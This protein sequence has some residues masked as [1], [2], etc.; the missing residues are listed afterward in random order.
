MKIPLSQPD[1]DES[2]IEAVVSVLRSN[3]LSL[4]PKLVEFEN[5]VAE[6][7]DTAHGVAVSSGTAGLHLALLALGIGEGDEVI[8]PSFAFIAVAN[9]VRQVRATPVFVDIDP[10]SLNITAESI[11]PAI[12]SRT[13][14]IL[15]VHT[16]GYP[17]AMGPII[18]LARKCNLR[19]IEDA[20]EAIGAEWNGRKAGSYGDLGVFSFYPNK[21]LT[22]GEGGVVVT[23][24]AELAH[25]IRALRNQGRKEGDGWL[26]HSMPGYNYRMP[27]MSCALGLS[28]L[29]RFETILARREAVAKKYY[30]A[31]EDCPDLAAPPIIVASGRISWFAFVVRLSPDLT[32]GER[33]RVVKEL[34]E[35]GIQARAYFPAIH[36]QP[37]YR[38]FAGG[39]NLAV[40]E[41]ISLRTL[42]L[43]F[44]NSLSW[45]QISTVCRELR[46]ILLPA[47]K[48]DCRRMD[49]LECSRSSN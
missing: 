3:Q 28:Q 2:D 34:G 48:K 25:T 14:A 42:A 22:T 33:D 46:G 4:G 1:I 17:A 9:A 36:L 41:G 10:I 16:F 6:Y 11:A 37:A 21:P 23:N 31:L 20:C 39:Q 38:E 44:F 18:E 43:P 8:I 24:S 5:A 15:V 32:P 13:R 26:E 29:A 12:T 35:A 19:V 7:V 30:K 27:E 40:T 45:D 47:R 49:N